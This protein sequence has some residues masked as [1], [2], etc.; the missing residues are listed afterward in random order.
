MASLIY[1]DRR[2]SLGRLNHNHTTECLRRFPTQALLLLLLLA[3]GKHGTANNRS[4]RQRVDK[5]LLLVYGGDL[6]A[7]ILPHHTHPFKRKG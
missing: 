6:H 5:F 7:L 3:A 1:L 4:G 2:C